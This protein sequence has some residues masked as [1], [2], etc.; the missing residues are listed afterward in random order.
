MV[1][2]RDIPG[3]PGY[4]IGSDGSVWSI[5]TR[6]GEW[7]K[8]WRRL[9]LS[10]RRGSSYVTACFRSGLRGHGLKSNVRYVHRLVLEAFRG[11]CPDGMEARHLNGARTD[12]RLENLCWG[13]REE[14]IADKKAHGTMLRGERHP[15][16]KFTDDDIRAMRRMYD[17]GILQKTIA[18]DFNTDQSTVGGIVRRDRWKHV[19]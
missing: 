4:R 11:P 12:N 8:T 13:T 5:R 14:N 18:R 1:E 2:Y 16:S 9:K 3:F 10:S 6:R 7:A 17:E 19:V 15:N